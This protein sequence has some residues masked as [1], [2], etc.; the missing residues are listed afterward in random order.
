MPLKS[1]AKVIFSSLLF[2]TSLCSFLFLTVDLQFL[3]SNTQLEIGSASYAQRSGARKFLRRILEEVVPE[4]VGKATAASLDFAFAPK[5]NATQPSLMFLG[6]LCRGS[7]GLP[8]LHAY[9]G[10][11]YG[12]G[13]VVYPWLTDK[14][15]ISPNK[16]GSLKLNSVSSFLML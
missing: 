14:S 13:Q 1:S 4:V 9:D 12:N 8:Y 11:W 3:L 5:Q 16:S 10:K 2:L 7:N 6:D 15:L